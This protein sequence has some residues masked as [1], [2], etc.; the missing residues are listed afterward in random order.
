[1]ANKEFVIS[2]MSCNGCAAGLESALK[3]AA[4]IKSARVSFPQKSAVVEYDE[5][6][7]SEEGISK[8]V[9]KAGFEI[10]K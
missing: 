4:G 8:V 3:R 7:I 2:G 5:S 9:D 6:V 10:V 1:M